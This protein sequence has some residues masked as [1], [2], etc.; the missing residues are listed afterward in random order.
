M[1]IVVLLICVCALFAFPVVASDEIGITVYPNTT[2]MPQATQR[3]LEKKAPAWLAARVYRTS[4]SIKDVAKY[5]RQQA[6]KPVVSDNDDL[7]KR[8]LVDNWKVTE[9]TVRGAYTLFGVGDVLR[10][11]SNEDAKTSFGVF[12]LKDSIVRV[13]LMSPYPSDANS[14]TLDE[15]TMILMIRERPA[16]TTETAT[17]GEEETVYTG[18]DVTRRIRI[19]NKPNPVHPPG[20]YGLVV[21]KAVLL[22]S[23]KVGKIVI[24]QGVPGLTEE[25]IKAAR[26][27]EFD[28]AIKDGKYVSMWVQLEYHFM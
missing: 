10:K 9:G 26:R 18:R 1:K 21:L 24:V 3:L 23:G 13:H 5:F 7:V 25:A 6:P 8:L 14:N 4:D 22:G 27:L 2:E 20:V 16:D 12:V 11:A 28:P 17:A 15:G 19:R